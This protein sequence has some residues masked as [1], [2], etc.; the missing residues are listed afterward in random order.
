MTA[1]TEKLISVNYPLKCH[2]KYVFIFENRD[3]L[4]LNANSRVARREK[5]VIDHNY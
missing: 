5:I 4:A 3:N 2:G 1:R